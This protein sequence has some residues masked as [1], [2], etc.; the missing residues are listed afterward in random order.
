VKLTDDAETLKE[1]EKIK[2]VLEA[3]RISRKKLLWREVAFLKSIKDSNANML[4]GLAMES[5]KN[6]VGRLNSLTGITKPKGG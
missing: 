1:I 5:F 4:H 3:W 6:A 2:D